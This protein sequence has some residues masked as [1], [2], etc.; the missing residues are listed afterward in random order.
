M[1]AS[2]E[3]NSLEDSLL[4]VDMKSYPSDSNTKIMP[5]NL[6]S[7]LKLTKHQIIIFTRDFTRKIPESNY[8]TH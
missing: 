5:M 2:E 1:C 6:R 8:P 4:L 3:E 7:S